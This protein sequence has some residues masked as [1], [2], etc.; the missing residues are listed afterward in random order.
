MILAALG[1]FLCV[2][3]VASVDPLPSW[4]DSVAKQ[5]IFD[6]VA[7]VTQPG[8]SYIAPA[9]RIVVFDDDG[10]LWPD[11]G[12]PLSVALAEDPLR[13]PLSGRRYADLVYVPMREMVAFLRAS[14]FTVYIVARG[15]LGAIRPW[16]SQTFDVPPR[17]VVGGRASI[18]G[19]PIMAFAGS[20]VGDDL[21]ARAGPRLGVVVVHTDAIAQRVQLDDGA[22]SRG[23]LV[24]D[25]AR[26][27][28]RGL[29]A[30]PW[31]EH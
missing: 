16:A 13:D 2:T 12:L 6:F 29:P 20:A 27:W 7:N 11:H 28:R 15:D 4:R 17:H 25:V 3:T 26:D 31:P 24:V 1:T 10:T 9:R 19:A 14:G 22:A 30:A 5:R 18:A 21:L 8:P 23:W